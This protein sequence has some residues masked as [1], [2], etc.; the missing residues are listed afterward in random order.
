MTLY[1]LNK[2]I[3]FNTIPDEL[4]DI[5]IISDYTKIESFMDLYQ[6]TTGKIE[7]LE[8]IVANEPIESE[9]TAKFNADISFG[10]KEL[11]SLLYYLGYLTISNN[12]FGTLSFS[13]PNAVI[14]SVYTEYFLKYIQNITGIDKQI[15]TGNITKEII[16][17]GK[18]DTIIQTLGTYLSKLSNRDY[19]KFDENTQLLLL[20]IKYLLK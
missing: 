18:I 11:I 15:S 13:C 12:E 10:E 9:L 4:I 7:L 14:R 1:F 16:L 8:K 6:N 19:I 2:Y 5:N 17:H 20:K 3:R